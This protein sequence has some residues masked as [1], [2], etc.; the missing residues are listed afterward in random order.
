ML[1]QEKEYSHIRFGL[2]KLI[3]ND[4][5]NELIWDSLTDSKI[6]ETLQNQLK[7]LNFETSVRVDDKTNGLNVTIQVDLGEETGVM[8]FQVLR[9]GEFYKE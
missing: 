6:V 9:T 2:V 1:I 3:F 5:M 4:V 7:L 8:D